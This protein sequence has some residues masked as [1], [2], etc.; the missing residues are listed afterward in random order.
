M[1]KFRF[2]IGGLMLIGLAAAVGLAALKNASPPWAGAMLLL[3]CA[4]L[5][6]GIVGAIYRQGTDTAVRLLSAW[7][8]RTVSKIKVGFL[9]RPVI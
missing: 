8:P 5:A 9:Y 4:V 2:S 1:R 3:T 7:P 6:L